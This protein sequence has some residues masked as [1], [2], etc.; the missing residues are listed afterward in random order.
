MESSAAEIEVKFHVQRLSE[1][2]ARIL[3]RGG[4][5]L[6]PRVHEINLRFDT[7]ENDLRRAGRA[8]RLRRDAVTTLTY[9]GP[10]EMQ[11]GIRSR[12]ELEVEV[13]DLDGVRRLLEGLGYEVTFVYEKHRTTYEMGNARIMLDEL[14][15]GDFVEIEGASDALRLIA[16]QLELDWGRTVSE[17]YMGLF[18]GLKRSKALPFRDLTFANFE[19]RSDHVTDVGLKAADR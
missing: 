3:D 4:K 17:S 14:P 10:S 1:I 16:A 2:A 7:P 13:S 11:D 12:E 9:K 8:L 6:S 19:G 5:L 15:Y 18:D